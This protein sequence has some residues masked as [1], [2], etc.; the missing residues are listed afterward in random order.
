MALDLDSL[1]FQKPIPGMSL[2]TE[3][4]GRPWERPAKYSTPEEALEFYIE[5]L[6]VPRRVAQ[7]LEILENGYPATSLVDS[8]IVNGVMQGLHSLDVAI[9]IAPALFELL[10]GVAN[11]MNLKYEDGLSDKNEMIDASLIARAMKKPEAEQF[12]E[13]LEEEDMK[14]VEEAASLMAKPV[15]LNEEEPE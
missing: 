8:I 15:R 6:T 2:T 3:P 14:R 7:M 10:T 13:E 1:Q 4:K 11:S 12:K 5:Q 9:I